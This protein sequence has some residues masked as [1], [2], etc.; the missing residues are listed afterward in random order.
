MPGERSRSTLDERADWGCAVQDYRHPLQDLEI[1]EA[2]ADGITVQAPDGQLIYANDSAARI[3][4][5]DRV[6]DLLATPVQDVLKRFEVFDE[7][8]RPIPTAELPGRRALEGSDPPRTVLGFRVVATGEERWALVK[9]TPILDADG[10]V[11]FAVNVFHDVTDQKRVQQQLEAR[12]GQQNAIVE[13]GRSALGATDVEA[14][15]AMAMQ[16]VC[17]TLH[18]DRVLVWE[19]IEEEKLLLR[20]AVGWDENDIGS[21]IV[22]VDDKSQVGYT[23][24]S[25]RAVVVDDLAQETRFTPHPTI[26]AAGVRSA[27]NVIIPTSEQPFGVLSAFSHTP[28]HFTTDDV[29]FLQA[30]ANILSETIQRS[31]SEGIRMELLALERAARDEAETVARRLSAIQKVMEVAL[32]HLNL[33]DLLNQSLLRI[34]ELLSVDTAAILLPCGDDEL[35]VAAAIGLEV[36]TAEPIPQGRG[37]AGQ[38]AATG[39]PMVVD[40][41]TTLDVVSSVLGELQ[42]QS[43]AGVPL[44]L[45]EGNG[46]LHVGSFTRRHFMPEEVSLLQVVAERAAGAIER[47]HL[48]EA[49]REARENAVRRQLALSFLAQAS[50][51]LSQSLDPKDTLAQL[52]RLAVPNLAD[53]CIVELVE[54]GAIRTM[55]VAHNDP[56]KVALAW[57][58]RERYPLKLDD[59]VGVATVLKSG[60]SELYPEVTDELLQIA[61]QDDEH[62][63]SLRDL[64][65]RSAMVVPMTSRGRTIGA[66]TFVSDRSG[67]VYGPDDVALAE[68]LAR[69]AAL[70]IDNAT[71]F[72][73]VQ[74]AER[75]FRLLVQSLGAIFWEADAETFQFSFVS[76]RAEDLLGY[77]LEQWICPGSGRAS[78]TPT[79]ASRRS[80]PWWTRPRACTTVTSSTARSRQTAGSSG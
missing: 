45:P 9:A 5:F 27:I 23:V 11:R 35:C 80:Q 31:W 46:V 65:L 6:A 8:G 32:T 4:G 14:F 66:I 61:A 19:L 56:S 3:L 69:R 64:G 59:P 44:L 38:V 10:K 70:A 75:Q 72:R 47:S 68:D 43:V 60:Q 28:R 78:S 42:V 71:L 22:P 58:L 2:V 12:A 17:E 63:R 53:W 33:D 36:E 7:A 55:E 77:P 21:M 67:R 41:V 74:D 29:S 50:D 39:Q 13:L 52:V 40:D 18:V 73:N 51:M 16:T 76:Q 24:L 48:F 15:I 34:K 79:I 37:F 57:E 30:V 20:A 26:K 1:L 49:E 25:E 62:L 54:D